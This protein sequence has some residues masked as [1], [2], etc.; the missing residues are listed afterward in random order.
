MYRRGTVL[1]AV[2]VMWSC[3][4]NPPSRAEEAHRY[5]LTGIVV[6]LDP[7][8]RLAAIKHEDIQDDNGK[9]WMKAMT[10]EFPVRAEQDFAKLQVGQRIRATVYQKESDFEYWI[11]GIQIDRQ[12]S[13]EGAKK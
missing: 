5:A 9:V 10:M 11:S 1:V 8:G 3:A 2:A 13:K 6:R 12:L 7:H 4:R